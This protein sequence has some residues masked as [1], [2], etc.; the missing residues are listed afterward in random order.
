[1][2]LV[3]FSLAWSIATEFINTFAD[4]TER[5]RGLEF[6]IVPRRVCP[7]GFAGQ[8]RDEQLTGDTR[9]CHGH[10]DE[11]GSAHCRTRKV[12]STSG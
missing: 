1:M 3:D 9:L 11:C 5:I 7:Y 8:L 2:S 4:G 12:G 6:Q 10:F